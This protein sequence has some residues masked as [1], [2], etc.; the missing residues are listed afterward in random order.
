M[1]VHDVGLAESP[2]IV[3]HRSTQHAPTYSAHTIAQAM[4][5]EMICALKAVA[6]A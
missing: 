4:G 5:E 6:A 3:T 2:H 1:A